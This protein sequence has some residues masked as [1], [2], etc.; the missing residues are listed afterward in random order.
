MKRGLIGIKAL[1]RDNFS[2]IALE[3]H[4]TLEEYDNPGDGHFLIRLKT[5]C[6]IISFLIER[7]V[8][9]PNVSL[10]RLPTGSRYRGNS[11]GY[12]LNYLIDFMAKPDEKDKDLDLLN[13]EDIE[14]L[15]MLT[16]K[17]AILFLKESDDRFE[18]FQAFVDRKA[19]ELM[20]KHR[21]WR[22]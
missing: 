17:Y 6:L 8:L 4:S 20:Q 14:S 18:E 12:S 1:I 3:L 5:R 21:E 16:R 2:V 9:W 10:A 22:W 7:D 13:V 19:R 11:L 15:L